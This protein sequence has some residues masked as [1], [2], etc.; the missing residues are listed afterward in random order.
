M[1]C[2]SLPSVGCIIISR[3]CLF[4]REPSFFRLG[5]FVRNTNKWS[6]LL[7]SMPSL[8]QKPQG[9]TPTALARV[10]SAIGSKYLGLCYGFCTLVASTSA[11]KTS[12]LALAPSFHQPQHTNFI[13]VATTS[14][15]KTSPL[16]SPVTV[17]QLLLIDLILA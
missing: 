12:P 14:V 9:S 17:Y 10:S 11:V 15:V 7:L 6:A 8:R 5:L 13:L 2:S 1:S 3:F 16:A 4:V